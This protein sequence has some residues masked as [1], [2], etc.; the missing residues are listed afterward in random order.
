MLLTIIYL[1]HRRTAFANVMKGTWEENGIYK[2]ESQR[3]LQLHAW[4]FFRQCQH[5]SWEQHS[6]PLLRKLLQNVLHILPKPNCTTDQT[7]G[8][9]DLAPLMVGASVK[10][11]SKSLSLFLPHFLSAWCSTC[12]YVLQQESFICLTIRGLSRVVSLPPHFLFAWYL[13]PC[14]QKC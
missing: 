13:H 1:E 11:M 14:L 3:I 8:P 2:I 9:K 7:S 5:C 6:L 10:T 12:I 4:E